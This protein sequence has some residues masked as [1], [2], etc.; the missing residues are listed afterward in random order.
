MIRAFIHYLRKP[1]KFDRLDRWLKQNEIKVLD[2]GCGNH[3]PAQTKAFYPNCRYYGLDRSRAYNLDESDFKLME[4]FYEIDLSIP[5]AID[6]IPNLYFDCVIISHVIEHL[7]R[8]EEVLIKMVEK[9]KRGGILYIE[10]PR[11][12]SLSLP[13]LKGR[14]FSGTLN[15]YDDPTH[16]RIHKLPHLKEFLFKQGCQ[17]VDSGTRRSHKR[18][19]LLPLYIIR[20]FLL[21]S[22]FDRGVFW[23]IGGFAEYLIVKKTA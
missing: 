15:F 4:Q 1:F 14:I 2:V 9:L 21:T 8:A 5:E 3:S 23:D 16:I 10:Y 20:S 22:T 7:T 6:K 17:V 13:R 11:E 19:F 12:K 18:I